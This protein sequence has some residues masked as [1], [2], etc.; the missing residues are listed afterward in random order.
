LSRG[1]P[2]SS[3]A[4]A[5]ALPTAFALAA[6]A[7]EPKAGV[8]EP[9]SAD[10]A[11]AASAT[12]PGEQGASD[13]ASETRSPEPGADDAPLSRELDAACKSPD[14]GIA[15]AAQRLAGLKAIGQ[16]S[17]DAGEVSLALRA[18]GAPYVWPHA[19]TLEGKPNAL[20][21]AAQLMTTWQ[22]S[23]ADGGERRCGVGSA[24]HEDGSVTLAV[25]AIDALADLQPLPTRARIGAWLDVNAT[26]LVSVSEAKVVV[27]GPRGAPHPVPTS[28]DGPHVRARFHADRAGA[29]LVQ[30]LASVAGGPRPVL[31]AAVY[32]G[33]EP[34]K[35]LEESPAPGEL[36]TDSREPA[37]SL[38]EM[39]NRARAG[40]GLRPLVLNATLT[41]LATEHANAMRAARHTAHD[42]GD[43]D[44]NARLAR[45]GLQLSAG[46][47]VAHAASTALAHRVL[48]ASPSHRQNLLN[49]SFDSIGIGVALD[50]DGSAWVCEE[51][52]VLR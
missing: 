51:F 18:A 24:E 40:E 47:N 12:Q 9:A 31:E 5:L 42:T 34:P 27:L 44:L 2:S 14:R 38:F 26:L 49:A 19:W 1:R 32:V 41:H 15:R 37:A 48:W 46:E 13:F 36:A 39:V 33:V 6:L 7:C 21:N 4:Q 28:L 16:S 25:V 22:A 43:G 35:S 8:S 30:V 50:E 17:L 29:W 52:A 45:A 23:F 10:R 3:L 20:G 11:S